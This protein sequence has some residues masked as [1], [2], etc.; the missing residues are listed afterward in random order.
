MLP[1]INICERVV[2]IATGSKGI[3]VQGGVAEVVMSP[4]ALNR[5]GTPLRSAEE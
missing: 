1:Q 2:T 5:P 3:Q 4:G